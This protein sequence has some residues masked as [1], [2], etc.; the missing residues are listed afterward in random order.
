[1]KNFACGFIFLVATSWITAVPDYN[2]VDEIYHWKKV[3]FDG[4]PK[5]ADSSVG[6]YPYYIPENN[7]INDVGYHAAS[8]LVLVTILRVRPGVPITV[9]AFCAKNYEFGSSP[10]IWGF[11][12]Y[13]LNTLQ[14][15]D[16]VKGP[17]EKYKGDN[18]PNPIRQ[19]HNQVHHIPTYYKPTIFPNSEQSN[20]DRI[21]SVVYITID[22][23]CNRVFFMDNG[24]FNYFRNTTYFVRKPTLVAIDLPMNGCETKD[25][26]TIRRSEFSNRI[27]AYGSD[28]FVSPVIDYYP[29]GKC[30]E[31]FV[32]IPNAFFSNLFVYDYKKDD[33]WVFEHKTFL[34]VISES[35]FIFDK[36]IKYQAEF[37]IYALALGFAD[38]Y[39]NRDVYYAP[40]ASTAQYSVSTKILKDRRKFPMNFHYDDFHIMGYKGDHHQVV[41]MAVDY[42]YGILFFG[43]VQSQ[44]IRCWNMNKPLNPDN[45]GVIF[46]SEKLLVGFEVMIDSEG[47]LWCTTNQIAVNYLTETY[48]DHGKVNTQV[49]RLKISDAIQGT[50]CYG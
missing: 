31:P 35:Y 6:P 40:M 41:S 1:M 30:D 32:Y 24:Q 13:G 8:G 43:E 4:L 10:K 48:L 45:I 26:L 49:F 38:K 42:K 50:V 37:G 21:I 33:F 36:T 11:P 12:N 17:L 7:N 22:D 29:S 28:G 46:E 19:D 25:F 27:A 23:K 16:F 18:I 20:L 9:G 3:E 34:P 47:Y 44:Q 14:D 5:S 39:G 2:Y 15:S